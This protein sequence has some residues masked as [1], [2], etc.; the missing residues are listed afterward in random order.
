MVRV[1]YDNVKKNLDG[2]H[3]WVGH[4][5]QLVLN[6]CAGGFYGMR[7]QRSLQKIEQIFDHAHK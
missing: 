2:N 6:W 1:A 5:P 7:E 4:L 3:V